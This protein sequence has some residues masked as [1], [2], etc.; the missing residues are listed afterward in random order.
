MP[1]GEG[2]DWDPSKSKFWHWPD[3]AI[4]KRES[5]RLR[6]EHN[7]EMNRAARLENL[8]GQALVYVEDQLDDPVN[9]PGV[10]KELATKIRE[11]LK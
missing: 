7:R 6:E 2:A 8:L 4:G 11:E 3:R 9:K 1:Q 10:I 5:R